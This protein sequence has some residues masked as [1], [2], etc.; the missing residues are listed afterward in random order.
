VGFT[1][2]FLICAVGTAALFYLDRDKSVRNAKALWLPVIW[3]WIIGSRPVSVWL[4]IW[5]GLGQLGA[6]QGLDAQLDGSPADAL[7]FL[8]LSAAA[9]AV[10]LRR[11][12]RTAL[13]LKASVP[14]MIYFLYC[15][16]SCSWSPFPDVAFKRWIKDLGDLAMVLVVV[17]DPEPITAL[18]RLFSRVGF[19]LLPASILLIRYS[20]LGRAYDPSGLP[21]NT[22]VTTNKNTL[23]LITFVILLGAL[24][25]FLHLFR[26]KRRPN[27]TRQLVAQ[28]TLVAFGVAVLQQSHSATSGACFILGAVLILAT[29]MSFIGRRTGRVHALVLTIL[30]SGGITMLFGGVGTIAG[31]FGRNSTLGDRT[32]IWSDVIPLCP[33]PVIGAGFESFWNGY[34]KYVTKGLSIYEQGLNSA[35]NGY[36]EVYLNLGWLGVGLIAMLLISSYQRACAAFRLNPQVGG[37]MLTYVA[38]VSIYSITEA[39]FRIMTPTWIS[40]LLVLV[41][42]R[43]I[44]SSVSRGTKRPVGGSIS[45]GVRHATGHE[46]AVF[47]Y[48]NATE[49]FRTTGTSRFKTQVRR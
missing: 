26:D 1:L 6:G 33:N 43:S 44:A 10:L 20:S 47:N 42:S 15:L 32:I 18:R 48:G 16:V 21:M 31:A 5:F 2:A 28:G 3:L 19:I 4:G 37:L 36:I 17:T 24:W 30:L 35:H 13:L 22:G 38:T 11:K 39:G 8:A 9:V 12:R 40:F 46:L 27:R 45:Q 49:P 14:I 7:V 34:G 41:G 29:N 23:G 25:S